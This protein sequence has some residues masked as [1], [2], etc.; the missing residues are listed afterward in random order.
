MQPPYYQ[1][2]WQLPQ[3]GTFHCTVYSNVRKRN[4]FYKQKSVHL[5]HIPYILRYMWPNIYHVACY[6][7]LYLVL[8]HF[9]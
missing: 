7:F 2:H 3:K 5:M 1:F 9:L 8:C 6:R 4:T